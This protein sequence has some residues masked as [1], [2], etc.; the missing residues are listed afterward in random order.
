MRIS[1]VSKVA[2]CTTVRFADLLGTSVCR[3]L[4]ARAHIFAP[5]K[6]SGRIFYEG[7]PVAPALRARGV[8]AR[9]PAGMCPRF[10]HAARSWV[11]VASCR[12]RVLFST[13]R[14]A[15]LGSPFAPAEAVLRLALRAT[16][17]HPSD[18][19]V[20]TASVASTNLGQNLSAIIPQ[21]CDSISG[22]VLNSSR[23]FRGL[24][25]R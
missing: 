8:H 16:G 4:R 18:V 20:S 12:G 6:M 19:G 3:A 9:C 24:L 10:A 17:A 7:P 1:P 13:P 15:I 2:V 22:L 11:L 5:A 21:A 25:S 14:A 23:R